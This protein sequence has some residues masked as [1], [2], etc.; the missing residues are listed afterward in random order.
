VVLGDVAVRHPD[1]GIRHVEQDVHGLAGSKQHRVLP[2]EVGLGD[3]VA[4]EDEEAAGPVDVER[5]V[6]RVVGVLLVD[7][8]DLHLVAD[9]E[10]PVDRVPSVA[11]VLVDDEPARVLR[12]RLAVD[13]DHVVLPLDA[14]RRVVRMGVLVLV[15]MLALLVP[16]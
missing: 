6:H 3:A 1:A 2:D 12:C 11:G 14:P 10:L 13:L 5:V 4:A 16:A 7:D 8:P 15:V 9:A